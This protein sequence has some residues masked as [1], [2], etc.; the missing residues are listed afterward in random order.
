MPPPT[1]LAHSLRP[2]RFF[3]HYPFLFPTFFGVHLATTSSRD[4][5]AQA[6][7]AFQLILKFCN[8]LRL[9]PTSAGHAVDLALHDHWEWGVTLCGGG[10][11][12]LERFADDDYDRSQ[13]LVVQGDGE[14]EEL[15][16]FVRGYIQ[17]GCCWQRTLMAV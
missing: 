10:E 14:E 12:E 17:S 8:R 2:T 4:S 7:R 5:E 13:T 1:F 15:E 9:D 3:F 16:R 6:D 11:E